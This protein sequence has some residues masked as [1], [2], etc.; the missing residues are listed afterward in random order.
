MNVPPSDSFARGLAHGYSSIFDGVNLA[1]LLGYR[2]IVLAGVDLYNKEYFWLP[3]GAT[4]TY[5]KTPV[6]ADDPFVAGELIAEM[7]GDW[8]DYLAARHVEL[9]VLNPASRLAD[10]IPVFRVPS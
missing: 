6:E 10:R 9:L 1:S 3:A 7:M 5:E 8:R 4:R 2:R